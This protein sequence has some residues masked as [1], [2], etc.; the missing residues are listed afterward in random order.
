MRWCFLSQPSNPSERGRVPDLQTSDWKFVFPNSLEILKINKCMQM[1]GNKSLSS[2]LILILPAPLIFRR[3]YEFAGL[4]NILINLFSFG[5]TKI[6]WFNW[7]FML[8]HYD[9]PARAFFTPVN[10]GK[11][12]IKLLLF[13]YLP[14]L[15]H[16]GISRYWSLHS[17]V[18]IGIL[19][20]CIHLPCLPTPT[21]IVFCLITFHL[22]RYLFN[23]SI[24]VFLW[25]R[26]VSI[27]YSQIWYPGHL[28]SFKVAWQVDGMVKKAFGTL[29]FISEY[30][31]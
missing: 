9:H 10:N 2:Y 16:S 3:S 29:G 14:I 23:Q 1:K 5:M 13:L 19:I 7:H 21:E 31:V 6:A 27:L 18:I 4:S 30:W 12:T 15:L 17:F 28:F 26:T 25:P 11:Y 8:F 24:R 20:S 22:L